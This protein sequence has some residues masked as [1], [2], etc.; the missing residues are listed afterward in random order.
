MGI[1]SKL[2]KSSQVRDC[3][4][5]LR[6]LHSSFEDALFYG[7]IETQVAKMIREH[8]NLIERKILLEGQSP[9]ATVLHAISNVA[10]RECA[11]GMNHTYRGVLS[12]EGSSHRQVFAIATLK[13]LEMGAIDEETAD[14]ARSDFA[15]AVKHSLD[16]NCV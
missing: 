15:A 3:E 8:P 11:S 5:A 13:L 4:T 1:F 14:A 16:T 10:F 6:L 2:F 12:M 7:L 9:Q